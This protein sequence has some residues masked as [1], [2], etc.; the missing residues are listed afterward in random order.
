MR[1][2]CRVEKKKY[3]SQDGYTPRRTS[4]EAF[5]VNE[6][7]EDVWPK[8]R[9]GRFDNFMVMSTTSL[10]VQ[11]T[12]HDPWGLELTGL[13]FQAGGLNENKY[14]YQGKEMMGD[15]NLN[16]YD[17]HA[18]GYDPVIGRTWQQDP[19]S[20]NYLS[21]SPYSWAANNPLK[22]IDPDGKDIIGTDGKSV[23]Y[24]IVNGQAVWSTNASTDVKRV[25]NALLRTETGTSQLNKSIGSD[26][27]INIIVSDISVKTESG[28]LAGKTEYDDVTKSKSTGV[29]KASSAK[30]TI[31]EGSIENLISG[32]GGSNDFSGS[33]VNQEGGVGVAAGHELEHATNPE[34]VDQAY[35]NQLEGQRNDVEASPNAVHKQIIKEEIVKD[36]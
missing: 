22:F 11:E 30:V 17:F 19:H 35:K 15:H 36:I 28:F 26:V 7:A 24:R 14:F 23:T 29:Y 8:G 31:Y 25:G 34:N 18:R 9:S 20:E 2:G 21:L 1:P 3:I 27:K 13:G 12:H 10:V 4:M 16:I 5:V 6:T 32:E 33:G